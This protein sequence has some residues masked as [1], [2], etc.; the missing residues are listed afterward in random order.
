MILDLII[1]HL[2]SGLQGVI[3]YFN[4]EPVFIFVRELI[5]VLKELTTGLR[6]L[7]LFEEVGGS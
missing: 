2:H 5:I 4:D 1:T 6:T 3:L 7:I